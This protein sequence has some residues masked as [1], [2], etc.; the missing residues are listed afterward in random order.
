MRI[1]RRTFM[2]LSAVGLAAFRGNAETAPSAEDKDALVVALMGDPQLFMHDHS[3]TH[4]A[5]AMADWRGVHHDFMV[6][7]GDLVQNKPEYYSDYT[8]AVLNKAKEPMYSVAGNAD[9]HAGL[10][11]Y[12][13][14]TGMP[15]YFSL[16]EKGLRF[17]FTSTLGVTGKSGHICGLGVEQMA[18]LEQELA[19]DRSSTT[20]IF[21]HPPVFETTWQS[22]DRSHLPFPGSMYLEESK[23]M[24]ALFAR[25]PNIKVYAHGHLHHSYGVK[26]EFG[27]AEYARQ[28]NVLHISVGAAECQKGSSVLYIEKDRIVAKVRDHGSGAWRDEFEYVHATATTFAP[29]PKPLD[30]KVQLDVAHQEFD[31]TFCWFHARAAAIREADNQTPA[32]VVMTMQKWFLSASDYFSGLSVLQRTGADGAWAGPEER[33]ELAWRDEG[34]GVTVGICDVTP[35]WHAPTKKLIGIGHTVRYK[36]AHLMKDPRPRETGY[37][38]FDSETRDWT[39]WRMLD[40]GDREKFFSSGCGCGQW[41][42]QP[43]GTLLVPIYFKGRDGKIYSTTVLRC[44][45]DGETLTVLEQGNELTLDVVR[46]CYEPSLT[47][48]GGRYYLTLR[49]DVKAYV[50]SS[51]NGMHFEPIKPWLFDDGEEIGSYNTQAHWISHSDALYLVYTRRGANNDHIIRNR[52][53]LFMAQVDTERLCLLRATERVIIPE[54]GAMMGNFGACAISENESWVTVGEGMYKDAAERGAEGCV[55]TARIQWDKPNKLVGRIN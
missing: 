26:D 37:A 43:G 51:I 45:F 38:V 3:M 19:S 53:P 47:F 54:R 20:I 6:A 18:W 46:G 24:R 28:D 49:N 1:D 55:F 32:E 42:V 16:Y 33:P 4:I 48:H 15:L 14:C 13:S 29:K 25:H 30:Y 41:L 35:G 17:I 22:E 34:E 44:D 39:D 12:Q 27:R 21:G 10:G 11:A 36:D 9:Y 23:E 2:G 5:T 52:A 31:G 40:M 50:S 7:L 8:K